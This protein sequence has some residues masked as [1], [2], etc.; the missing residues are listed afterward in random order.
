MGSGLTEQIELIARDKTAVPS[1]DLK[2]TLHRL[3]SELRHRT[4]KGSPTSFEFVA[5]AVR[6]LSKIKGTAHA[7]ARMACLWESGVFL[8]SNQHDVDALECGRQLMAL[9][10]QL[11]AKFWL[12][13]SYT[14]QG[15]ALSHIGDSGEALLQFSHAVELAKQEKDIEAQS[16]I[17]INIGNALNYAGLYREAI[18]YLRE[19][20]ELSR[21]HT[22]ASACELPALCNLAQSYQY[23][24]EYSIAFRVIDECLERSTEPIDA[25]AAFGRVVREATYVHL[26]LELG[27]LEAARLHAKTCFQFAQRSGTKRAEFISRVS[28]ALCEIHGGDVSK[29]LMKLEAALAQAGDVGSIEHSDAL[30]A[31]VRAYD[32][33]LQPEQ[34]LQHLRNLLLGIR[35]SRERGITSL[36]ALDPVIH[37]DLKTADSADLQE[38]SYCEARLRAQVAERELINSRIEMLERLAV[39]A[40]LKEEQS[41][42][43][44]YRVGKLA[45]LMGRELGWA[46]ATCQALELAARL[47]DIGK[48]AVPDRILLTSDA[49]KEEERRLMSV[50]TTVGAELLAKSQIPQLRLAEEI[51]RHHHEWWNGEGYP[52][53]LIGKRIPTHAR[54]V[55]LADVFDALTHGRPFSRPWS[56]ERALLEIANRKNTQFD[57][58]L[59]D[60]FIT[61]IGRLR[62]EHSNLDEYLGRAGRNSPFLQARSKIRRLLEEEREIEKIATMEGNETRH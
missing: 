34:A 50:H 28:S 48:I 3:S 22:S 55:A 18:P 61:L 10:R 19:A 21:R 35:Q 59:A 57:P 51:A 41:G 6:A 20:I 13:R 49:L 27:K 62:A 31:L 37:A 16:G 53:R 24:G 42:E 26:A 14:L 1:A 2:L 7:E 11:G 47:H 8:F 9:A 60:L 44:G 56:I 15:I 33:A 32:H 43:H 46:S 4:Q 36:L 25:F 38:L 54:I 40:D 23:L 17:L 5:T 58:E 30:T 39:T 29:G 12:R 45:G 52:S